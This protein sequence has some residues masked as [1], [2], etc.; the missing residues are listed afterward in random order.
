MRESRTYG[1]VRG[2]CDETHVPTATTPRVH[3]AARRRGGVAARGAHAAGRAG[4][5]HRHAL[6]TLE[7]LENYPVTGTSG[8]AS[9]WSHLFHSS[10]ARR[11]PSINSCRSLSRVNRTDSAIHLREMSG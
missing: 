9:T 2:A 8:R 5:P 10:P 1:S 4:A 3:H 11:K 6:E 7:T